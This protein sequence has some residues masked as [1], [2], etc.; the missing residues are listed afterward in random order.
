MTNPCVYAILC[1]VFS[2]RADGIRRVNSRGIIASAAVASSAFASAALA[3]AAV[4]SGVVQSVGG[5]RLSSVGGQLVIWDKVSP[6]EI[7][8]GNQIIVSASTQTCRRRDK[9]G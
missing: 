1:G 5:Q 4:P 2:E 3:S 7:A 9:E 6:M 8:P